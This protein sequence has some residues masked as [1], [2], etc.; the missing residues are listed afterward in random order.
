MN[1]LIILTAGA[2]IAIFITLI[3]PFW[4][5]PVFILGN[6]VEPVQYLPQLQEYKPAVLLGSVILIFSIIHFILKGDFKPAKC[7]QVTFAYLF[8]I[9]VAITSLLHQDYFYLIGNARSFI[10]YFLFL[11]FIKDEKQVT[12]ILWALII[13]GII[14][15]IY[16]LYCVKFN[17]YIKDRGVIRISSFF[18]NPNRFGEANTLLIPLAIAFLYDKY[19]KIIKLILLGTIALLLFGIT[20]SYS[21]KC[22]FAL[23]PAIFLTTTK[24]STGSKKITTVFVTIL[25]ILFAYFIMPDATKWRYHSAI[26]NVFK[27]ENAEELDAGRTETAKAGFKIMLESPIIGVGFGGFRDRYEDIASVS[28]EI[29]LHRGG[30]GQILRPHNVFIETGAYLGIVGLFFYVFA[31]YFSYMGAR[32]AQKIF[33]LSGNQSMVVA[34]IYLQVFIITSIILGQFSTFVTSKFFWMVLPISARLEV[35][36]QQIPEKSKPEMNEGAGIEEL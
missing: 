14:A 23:I 7:K 24:F 19:P 2:I 27:A 21:R 5:L 9:W 33:S 13:F 32:K 16:G 1:P 36:S 30:K 17:I 29:D 28:G 12:K 25:C 35:L 11:Y 34:S 8:I 26:T 20:E 31:V 4:V 6:F 15:G 22:F 18:S 3:E 10:P